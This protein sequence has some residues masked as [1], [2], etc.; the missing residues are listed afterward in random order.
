MTKPNY[1]VGN[2]TIAQITENSL[3]HEVDKALK[4]RE[5]FVDAEQD[6]NERIYN[7]DVFEGILSGDAELENGGAASEAYYNKHKLSDKAISQLEVLNDQTVN[8]NYI[9]IIDC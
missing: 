6:M 9:Q 7:A 8:F 5:T 2:L 4:G 3:L 1:I